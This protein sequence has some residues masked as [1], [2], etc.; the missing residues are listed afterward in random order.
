MKLIALILAILAI[1]HFDWLRVQHR[2]QWVRNYSVR[3]TAWLIHH[4]VHNAWLL[5]MGLLL[6]L[7]LFVG[8]IHALIGD[9]LFGI[10]GFLI[11]LFLLWY[12][13]WPLDDQSWHL[14]TGKL[15]EG[16]KPSVTI[17]EQG[18][19]RANTAIDAKTYR[20]IS[21]QI[22]AE[23]NE[24]TFA[25]IFWF[26]LLG[27]AGAVLYRAISL[28]R[29]YADSEQSMLTV[30][31]TLPLL[32]QV[33]DWVPARLLAFSYLIAGD[34]NMGFIQWSQY[35]S[36]GLTSSANLLIKTGLGALNIQSESF[37]SSDENRHV[38]QL[39]DRAL[40]VWLVLIAIFTLGTWLY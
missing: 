19:V 15:E 7:L 5:T 22:L 21:E 2:Y 29:I 6:P 25:V 16:A 38:Y 32:Q 28:L 24:K 1:R 39:Q 26:F 40:I 31:S 14:A 37:A 20:D 34:F 4:T 27:G 17:D 35:A 8:F 13:L 9:W 33:L 11:N 3:F 18:E 36:H 12:C 23:A 30:R 10:V